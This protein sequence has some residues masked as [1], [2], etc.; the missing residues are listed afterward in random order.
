MTHLGIRPESMTLTTPGKGQIDG[1]VD[2]VEYLGAD[3]YLIVKCGNDLQITVRVGGDNT[4]LEGDP[5][6]LCFA[7]DALHYFDEAGNGL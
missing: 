6:E 4:L 3:T 2:L 1:V 5:I 7:M